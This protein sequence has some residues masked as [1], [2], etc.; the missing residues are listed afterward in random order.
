MNKI[1]IVTI[2][3]ITACTKAVPVKEHFPEAPA[4]LLEPLPNL[5]PLT[6]NKIELSTILDNANTNYGEFYKLR[7]KMEGWQDWYIKQKEIFNK[8]HENKE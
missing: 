6:S 7:E 8:L 2:L 1:L 5:I 4:V 3:M